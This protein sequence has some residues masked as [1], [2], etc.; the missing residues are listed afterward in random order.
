[1]FPSLDGATSGKSPG[2]KSLSAHFGGVFKKSRPR[3]EKT[4]DKKPDATVEGNIDQPEKELEK[5]P[6]S[7]KSS[8]KQRE[9]SSDDSKGKKSERKERKKKS[10]K[11][12]N[13]STSSSIQEKPAPVQ[14][15]AEQA[16]TP[17]TSTITR[18]IDLTPPPK[19]INSAQEQKPVPPAI[20]A[21]T[22]SKPTVT[23][24]APTLPKP[25]ESPMGDI[26]KRMN[27]I[28]EVE[29]V[30]SAGAPVV[31]E[32]TGLP[33]KPV[34]PGSNQGENW[35]F[36]ISGAFFTLV[37]KVANKLP[38]LNSLKVAERSEA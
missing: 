14:E 26:I 1:M 32:A 38:S 16:P 30:P 11:S 34:K 27:S 4:S 8:K 22:P 29:R 9:Y 20:P 23:V 17:E 24:E 28:T 25:E 2:V 36:F 12:S 10:K 13:S 31:R 5:V 7:P 6:K 19:A 15:N 21:R 3:P 37:S 35:C 33:E 18:T